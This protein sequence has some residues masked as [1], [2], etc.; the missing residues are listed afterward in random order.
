MNLLKM[1]YQ[2]ME[3]QGNSSDQSIHN[4]K[5]SILIATIIKI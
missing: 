1:F 3:S 2:Y 4:I 5:I